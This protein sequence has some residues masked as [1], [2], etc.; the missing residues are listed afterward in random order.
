MIMKVFLIGTGVGDPATL[1]IEAKERIESCRVLVGAKRMIEPYRASRD[2][3]ELIDSEDIFSFIRGQ[4]EGPVGVLLS[5]DVGFYSGAAKLLNLLSGEYEVEAI[6]GISSL[7]Y[8][9]AKIGTPWQDIHIVSA[10]GREHNAAGEIQSHDKT[11]VLAGGQ[12]SPS[13]LCRELCEWGMENVRVWVGEN[14]SYPEERIV[15][16]RAKDFTETEFASLA[17]LVAENPAPLRRRLFGIPDAD[18]I[19]GNV[20]MTKEE[21]RTLAISKLRLEPWHTL[22]DIGAGTGSVSVEG[23]LSCIAGRVF[24][25]EMKEEAVAL[26]EEN[27]ARFGTGNLHIVAGRAPEAL[28]ALPPPNRVFLGGTTGDMDA[29]MDICMEKNPAVRFVAAAVTVETLSEAVQCFEKR[30]L[31][32]IDICQVAVTKVNRVGNYH[33]MNAQNPVFIISGEGSVSVDDNK[34]DI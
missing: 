6:P 31:A 27:K 4:A 1:T 10:H 25:V 28:A 9:C 33:M 11:F 21:V 34:E 29:I 16:G 5:G 30:G 24:A 20:P 7:L 17:V 18:F 32:D 12:N 14:L 23:A 26:I 19:R 13:K 22:W 2:C 3:A 15:S 8:F